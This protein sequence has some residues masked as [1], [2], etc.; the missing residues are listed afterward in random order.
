MKY[1]LV[2]VFIAVYLLFGLELGYCRTSPL[3]THFT[4]MFQHAT[5][6]HLILNAISFWSSYWLLEKFINKYWLFPIAA[7]I[8]FAASFFAMK[9]LPTVGAS[10]TVYAM[11]GM[12]VGMTVNGRLKIA[13]KKNFILLVVGVVLSLTIS[14]IKANS[15]FSLHLDSLLLGFIFA[16]VCLSRAKAK[17]KHIERKNSS[18]NL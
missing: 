5:I 6:L 12:L 3:Y 8:A 13:N 17:T 7:A 11:S 1:I 16:A 9:D 18:C 15:N 4:Y 10:A 14:L 2:A